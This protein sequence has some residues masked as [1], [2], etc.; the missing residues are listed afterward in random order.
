VLSSDFEIVCVEGSWVWVF[1]KVDR[2]YQAFSFLGLAVDVDRLLSNQCTVRGA[3][4][5]VS[6]SVL[7]LCKF[8]PRCC[9]FRY[10]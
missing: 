4:Q 10:Q 7:A 9:N 8:P 6:Q 1:G 2:L 5:S 3:Y